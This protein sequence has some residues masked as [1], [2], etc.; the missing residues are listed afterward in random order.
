MEKIK[1]FEQ[2]LEENSLTNNTITS[3]LA[4]VNQF[5]SFYK[6]FTMNTVARYKSWLAKNYKPVTVNLRLQGINKYL[7]FVKKSHIK[8]KYVKVS[9]RQYLD[10][11][12]SNDKY[13]FLKNELKNNGYTKWYFLVWLLATT[14]ARISEMMQMT[15][16]HIRIGYMDVRSKGNKI[17]R[18]YIPKRV[19]KA[20]QPWIRTQRLSWGHIF[21]RFNGNI[22]TTRWISAQ[23]KRFAIQY[24]IDKNVVYPHSFR[25]L[26]AKNFLQKCENIAL[27]ADLMGHARIETT[28]IYL[29][30][31]TSEQ[32]MIVDKIVTW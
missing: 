12:I 15:P 25:H 30:N 23:L 19:R 29:R 3:Y 27:L 13:K 16:E 6:N 18:I 21:T 17:R 5:Q 22:I 2:F 7:A 1:Q 31:T 28:R 10:N 4:A 8:Q 20:I 24:G 32:Q 26:Y 9:Q 11:V 14:G